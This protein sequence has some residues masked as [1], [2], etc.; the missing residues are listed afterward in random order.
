MSHQR[1][2]HLNDVNLS[3]GSM[4]QSFTSHFSILLILKN[5]G[6]TLAANEQD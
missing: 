1:C 5:I 3:L 2:M 6:L 4:L